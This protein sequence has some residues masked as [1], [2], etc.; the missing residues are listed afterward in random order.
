M[1][2]TGDDWTRSYPGRTMLVSIV[3]S[4]NLAHFLV[5]LDNTI[6]SSA[7]L[8]ITDQFY[9]LGDLGWYPSA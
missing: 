2:E 8:K 7:I 6:V 3:L 4:V 5:G 1:K 9:V